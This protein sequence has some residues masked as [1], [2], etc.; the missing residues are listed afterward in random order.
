MFTGTS[1]LG[2]QQQRKLWQKLQWWLERVSGRWQECP[3][4]LSSTPLPSV[5]FS[6]CHHT[7][8]LICHSG[9]GVAS[10][11]RLRTSFRCA[12]YAEKRRFKWRIWIGFLHHVTL[13]SYLIHQFRSYECAKDHERVDESVDQ[14]YVDHFDSSTAGK[15]IW[16]L[17]QFYSVGFSQ[18]RIWRISGKS[19]F[20]T[21]T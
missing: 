2:L 10:S 7:A 18:S 13:F 19:A 9:Q 1:S 16:S 12:A 17:T 3:T 21:N 15:Q 4:F 11:L 14:P 20:L 5:V 6:S 8:Q